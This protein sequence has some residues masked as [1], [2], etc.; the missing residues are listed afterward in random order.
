M[1]TKQSKQEAIR[2]GFGKALLKLGEQN[3]DVVAMTADLGSSVRMQDFAAE[4]P[5]R[6]FQIGI[7][8][9]NMAGI[10]AGLALSGKIPFAGSFACFQP[11]RN[12]DQIRSSISIM[13]ANVKLVSSHAGFSHAQDGVQIQ[14]LEDLAVMRALP[15]MN[16]VV[17]A[18][19][20]QAEQLTAQ[21]AEMEGPAYL[22]LGRSKTD[23]I[24]D[25]NLIDPE[26]F[27]PVE[28][29]KAQFL[30][31]G[32]DAVIIANGYMVN[33]ALQV[34]KEL[35]QQLDYHLSVLNLHT[36]K[37]LDK[38]TIKEAAETIG[39]VITIEEHQKIGG[40]GSAVAE[41]LTE[42][43]VNVQQK[44]I[45]VDDTFGETAAKPVE[46]WEKY[47]LGQQK[48]YEQIKDFLN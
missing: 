11:M 24:S 47:G 37:P 43:Q 36:L 22:R 5:E 44:I 9:Q 29:G 17:P 4:Y 7:A 32:S 16:V 21:I 14:V 38:E 30:T 8:E 45:G 18:D 10:A 42:S 26:V 48:L 31:R 25:S 27:T 39:K 23:K 34:V 41:L 1:S 35:K 33:Q 28:F 3:K 19:A 40:L 2:D 13:N 12:L 20:E 15:N 6:F 46:L